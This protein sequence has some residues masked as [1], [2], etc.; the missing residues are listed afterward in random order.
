M[1]HVLSMIGTGLPGECDQEITSI[2]LISGVLTSALRLRDL[3]VLAAAPS[4]EVLLR[5]LAPPGRLRLA[6]NN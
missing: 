3:M 1:N 4:L 2:A 5:V 6:R